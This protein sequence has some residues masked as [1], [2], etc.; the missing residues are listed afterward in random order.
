MEWKQIILS[1]DLSSRFNLSKESIKKAVDDLKEKENYLIGEDSNPQTGS[2]ERLVTVLYK[3]A[4][5]QITNLTYDDISDEIRGDVRLLKTDVAKIVETIFN[6][7][8]TFK[9][10]FYIRAL[11]KPN[12]ELSKIITWDFNLSQNQEN[13]NV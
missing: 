10:K 8:T 1:K 5:H 11:Y 12:E 2:Q 6:E 3:N 4:S 7:V 13:E 9:P